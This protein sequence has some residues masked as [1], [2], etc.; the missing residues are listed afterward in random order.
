MKP[1]NISQ[2]DLIKCLLIST[3]MIC[4][5]RSKEI[6]IWSRRLSLVKKSITSKT[7]SYGN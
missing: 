3:S 6:E 5:D 7:K 4:P 2:P 1:S